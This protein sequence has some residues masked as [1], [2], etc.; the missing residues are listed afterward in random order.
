MTYVALG[1]SA[2]TTTVALPA[3]SP[4][5]DTSVDSSVKSPAALRVPSLSVATGAP[6]K[7]VMEL[8]LATD[9]VATA[10]ALTVHTAPA[11]GV[12]MA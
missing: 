10:V 12:S 11:A 3:L 8:M 4:T 5:P 7:P 1:G 6:S 9:H 2:G